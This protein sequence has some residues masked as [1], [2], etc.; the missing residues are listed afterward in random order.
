MYSIYERAVMEGGQLSQQR[1]YVTYVIDHVLHPAQGEGPIV[2]RFHLA[3]RGIGHLSLDAQLDLLYFLCDGFSP[4]GQRSSARHW[5]FMNTR[6]ISNLNP[7]LLLLL[8]DSR[9]R[10]YRSLLNTGEITLDPVLMRGLMKSR[11]RRLLSLLNTGETTLDPVLMRGLMNS[12]SQAPVALIV[13]ERVE[14][15]PILRRAFR[16]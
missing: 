15:L 7:V 2:Y 1:M 5:N 6:E 10:G 11:P 16:H 8:M 9:L 13:T 12:C 4:Y 3:L 14:R